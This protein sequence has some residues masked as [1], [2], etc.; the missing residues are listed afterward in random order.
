M[1]HARPCQPASQKMPPPRPPPPRLLPPPL[2]PRPQLP[3]DAHG[4][5]RPRHRPSAS[6]IPPAPPLPPAGFTCPHDI[7]HICRRTKSLKSFE[8]AEFGSLAWA[9]QRAVQQRLERQRQKSMEGFEEACDVPDFQNS[10]AQECARLTSSS[11][12]SHSGDSL[13][14]KVLTRTYSHTGINKY[15]FF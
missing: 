3:E 15:C 7:S 9:L 14:E 11:A 12:S 8:D 1:D 6:A 2:P 5:P 13:V 4:A 10:L